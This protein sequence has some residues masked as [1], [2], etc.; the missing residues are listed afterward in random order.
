M[1]ILDH[2]REI[3]YRLEAFRAKR[4]EKKIMLD[5][6]REC[7]AVESVMVSLEHLIWRAET[8]S[9][10]Y[11]PLASKACELVLAIL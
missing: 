4:L 3:D 7:F 10:K 5:D 11:G 8:H 6:W 1:G 9:H 2:L